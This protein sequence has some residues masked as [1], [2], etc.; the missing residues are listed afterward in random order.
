MMNEKR[1]MSSEQRQ[2]YHDISVISFVIV[3]MTEYL[4]THPTDR[5]AMDYLNHYVRMQ[6]QAMRE[7]AMKYGPLR[8]SDADGCSQNEWKWATQ[9]WPWEGGC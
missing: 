6:N 2:L 5:D 4:D 1:K 7:Y 3:E 8:I 9:P